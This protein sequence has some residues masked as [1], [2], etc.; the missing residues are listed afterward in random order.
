MTA[1]LG[2]AILS[3]ENL[4]RSLAFYRDVVGLAPS[5]IRPL[6]GESFCIHWGLAPLSEA[7][8]CCLRMPGVAHAAVVLLEFAA[9]QR[10]RI[11]RPGEYT[12]RGHWNLN[13]Y[14]R[15][16]RA[17]ARDLAARGLEFWSEPVG[18]EVS[19]A[20]GAPIEVLFEGPDGVVI[21]LVQ[22]AG[23][24]D[25]VIGRVRAAV[26]QVGYTSTGWSA[27]ATTSHSTAD[28]T[29]AQRFYTQSFGLATLMDEIL[30]KPE[31][32]RFLRRPAQARTR[33][34]FLAGAH[35]YG[36]I[37]LSRL[38]CTEFHDA[39]SCRDGGAGAC[40]GR[41][42]LQRSCIGGRPGTGERM[43]GTDAARAGQRCAGAARRGA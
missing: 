15:D 31:T 40:S 13:F 29:A 14:V 23:G 2:A 37:A 3:C 24:A 38:S 34:V 42:S 1:G 26:E 41:V 17:V 28:A 43:R 20:S 19:A 6:R 12:V 16:I 9:Q 33:A 7:R 4:D 25:T 32:N 11:R 21:N 8:G 10:E 36:K 5:P 30:D 18:Y 35:P 27:V 22:L 39:G